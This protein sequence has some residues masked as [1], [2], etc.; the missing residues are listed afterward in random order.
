[1]SR[2]HSRSI[3]AAEEH[4]MSIRRSCRAA[5]FVVQIA[6][7]SLMLSAWLAEAQQPAVSAPPSAP[8]IKEGATV[9]VAAHSYVIPD[10]NV[11]GVPNVGVIVGDRGT[12]VIDTGLGKANG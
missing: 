7:S 2:L 10:M 8:M 5:L 9:K 11:G 12:L 1:M 3:R 4:S 6:A